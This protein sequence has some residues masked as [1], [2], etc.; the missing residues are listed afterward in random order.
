MSS[1]TDKREGETV[2]FPVNYGG[3][4][5]DSFLIVI[6]RGKPNE[7]MRAS[8]S[9]TEAHAI[10]T[11]TNIPVPADAPASAGHRWVVENWL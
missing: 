3:T 11:L 5:G 2:V 10:E 4:G 8:F 7:L 9:T 6:Q 1:S